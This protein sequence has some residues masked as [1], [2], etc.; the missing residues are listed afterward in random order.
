MNEP[1]LRAHW[2]AAQPEG[3]LNCYLHVV[4]VYDVEKTSS[5]CWL[6]P[7]SGSAHFK[8]HPLRSHQ[9]RVLPRALQAESA[10][11]KWDG[12]A[13]G[14]FPGC[15]TRCSHPYPYVTIY[16]AQVRESDKKSKV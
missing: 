6:C 13:F 1:S 16:V 8:D 3:T 4:L 15:F 9:R 5:T 7:N 10:V 2:A 11:V 12:L 14:A